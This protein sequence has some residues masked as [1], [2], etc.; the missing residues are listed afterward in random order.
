MSK[1]VIGDVVRAKTIGG[2]VMC[3]ERTNL[4]L[5]V[6]YIDCKR[7][8]CYWDE[9]CLEYSTINRKEMEGTTNEV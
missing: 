4:V 5:C 7:I 1:L 9:G 8:E 6:Y 2:P 3:V